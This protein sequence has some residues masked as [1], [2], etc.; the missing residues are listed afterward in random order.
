MEAVKQE[1]GKREL[2]K[3]QKRQA[4]TEAAEQLMREKGL[5]GLNMDEVA[6]RAGLAKGTLY[7]YY[8]S[9][10]EIW[11]YLTVQARE[12]LLQYFKD[13]TQSEQDPL[14]QIRGIMRADYALYKE[15]PLYMDLMSFFEVNRDL[16]ETEELYQTSMKINDY[17]IGIFE[18][19]KAQG[20][21]SPEVNSQHYSF[22][23]WGA[24]IGMTQLIDV[25][26][27]MIGDIA[28]MT[29]ESLFAEYIE[30]IIRSL[31]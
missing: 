1:P 31:K 7:L 14:N 18:N 19:A 12:T 30:M 20:A 28:G 17:I 25:K 6:K 21:I 4:I 3:R 8:K 11:A 2:K 5:H 10:E 15:N 9:K 26:K 16:E 23:M 29:E 24:T 22:M 13:Y 27:G